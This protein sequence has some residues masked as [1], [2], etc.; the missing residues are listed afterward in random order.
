MYFVLFQDSRFEWRWTLKAAN[1][2]PVAMSSEGYT[3]KFNCRRSIA[4]VKGAS[5]APIC[6]R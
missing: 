4:L 3:T 5:G 1:H 6:E 2:E